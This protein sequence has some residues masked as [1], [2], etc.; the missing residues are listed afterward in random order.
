MPAPLPQ[1]TREAIVRAID[2]GMTYAE[3]ASVLGVGAASVS[4]TLR[5]SREAGTLEPAPPGGGNPSPIRDRV[6]RVLRYLVERKLSD[7]TLQELAIELTQYTGVATSRSSI[8]RAL[9]RLGMTRKK[10]PSSRS[11]RTRQKT[12]RDGVPFALS[13][14]LPD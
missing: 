7:A 8:S 14:P 11:R 3:T 13:L 1:P 5:R 12:E 2:N 10:S 4:R 9:Q 6:L